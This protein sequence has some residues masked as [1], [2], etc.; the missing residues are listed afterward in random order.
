[1]PKHH[2]QFSSALVAAR[3]MRRQLLDKCEAI[4]KKEEGQTMNPTSVHWKDVG[5]L[6]RQ[7]DLLEKLLKELT[8]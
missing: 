4:A 8:Q 2:P 3:I 7:C 5:S 1:M 6:E